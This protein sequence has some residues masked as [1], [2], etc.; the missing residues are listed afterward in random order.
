MKTDGSKANLERDSSL[1]K[2][3][4]S[5]KLGSIGALGSSASRWGALTTEAV[6]ANIREM[7]AKREEKNTQEE[8]DK[9]MN[10]K[11]KGRNESMTRGF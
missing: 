8:M 1:N 11:G 7:A 2:L 3:G 6:K 5:S 9:L 4:S 10:Q